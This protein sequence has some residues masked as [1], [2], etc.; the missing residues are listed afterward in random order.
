MTLSYTAPR[1]RYPDLPKLAD[2]AERIREEI[3][4]VPGV[5]AAG[6]A[7]TLPFAESAAW[8]QGLSR[9]DPRGLSN[10]AVVP[11][12]HYNVV[13]TGYAEALGVP[14]KAGRTF[15]REDTASAPP[16]VIVNEALANR[17]FPNENPVGQH[18][19]VGHAPAL[20][21]EIRRTVV[22]VVGDARWDGLDTPAVPEAWVPIAQQPSG[23]LV[24]RTMF[25]M[26]QTTGD[27]RSHIAAVRARVTQVDK[28]L[29]LS[30][31][32]T[33]ESR[34]DES[35]WR[36]RLAASALGALGLAALTIALVGVFGI[37]SYLVGRR[38][39]EIGVRLAIGAAPRDII[40]LVMSES[41]SLVLIGIGLGVGGAFTL[42]RYLSA[43]LYGVTASDAATLLVTAFGLACAAMIAS[44]LPARRAA[45]IAPLITLRL[46]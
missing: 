23:D 35:V 2:L 40:R 39:H 24:L 12:V 18:L 26:F 16:V 21:S 8:F 13:S 34:L 4:H 5:V 33:L 28:D 36:Q 19:W 43:L 11:H 15:N 37:T 9:T 7:Q 22:G 20:P 6:A 44:Y 25:V 46:E 32:R 14:L 27:P 30:S 38:A 31:V 45:H 29:A 1:A 10:L 17:Y 3:S 42:A 41:A